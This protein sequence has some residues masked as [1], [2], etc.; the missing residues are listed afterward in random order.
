MRIKSIT[1]VYEKK[2]GDTIDTPETKF[3]EY[4]NK[5]WNSDQPLWSRDI[6][7][8]TMLMEYMKNHGDE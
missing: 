3:I 1:I 2:P 8:I 7:L 4:V 5:A 6:R